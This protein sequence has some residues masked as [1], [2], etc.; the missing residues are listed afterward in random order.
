VN[1]VWLKHDYQ[2][3][4]AKLEGK[5]PDRSHAD[6]TIDRDTELRTPDGE[7]TALLLCN[8]IPLE[9]RDLAF[10]LLKTVS[11]FPSNR[12]TAMGTKSLPRSVGLNG[13]LSPRRGV[14][15]RVLD[16]SP[17]RQGILGWDGPGHM[18]KLTEEHPEMLL[19]NERLAM[20]LDQ[21]Y[22]QHLPVPYAKQLAAVE[23][24]ASRWRLWKTSFTGVYVAKTFRTAYHGDGNLRGAMTVITP[25]GDFEG[26]ALVIPRWRLAIPYKPGDVLLFDAEELHGNLPFKGRRL[27]AAFYCGGWVAKCGG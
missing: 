7:I 13:S 19:G 24:H 11:G 4:A 26:G 18:A 8:V 15:K 6:R 10:K 5:F 1:T 14:N 12:S 21:L 23:E 3:V 25:L 2:K 16:A 17:A 27:S 9:L 20:L 22:K